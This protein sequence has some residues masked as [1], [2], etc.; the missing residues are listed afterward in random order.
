QHPEGLY[1]IDQHNSHERYLYEKLGTTQVPS[2]EL[3]LAKVL[4]LPAASAEILGSHREALERLGFV[5][6][7][8]G[9]GCWQLLAV[10]AV[11]PAEEAERT[12]AAL[13]AEAGDD[14]QSPM[15]SLSD[16]WRVTLACHSATK[17]GD[18]LSREAIGRL[19]EQWRTCEQPFTCPHGRPTAVLIPL[20]EL[21]RRCLR[22]MQTR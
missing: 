5:A 10:P 6:E 19:V 4:D 13:L 16:R 7:P 1:L 21:H 14:G 17:A 3:L 20:T 22:G 8:L 12:L 11:L 15:Q 2:Q 18:R 9:E